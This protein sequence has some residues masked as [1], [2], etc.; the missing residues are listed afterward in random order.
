M[1]YPCACALF[2][3][4]AGVYPVADSSPRALLQR[5]RLREVE[6]HSSWQP[7]LARVQFQHLPSHGQVGHAGATAQPFPLLQAGTN[8]FCYVLSHLTSYWL[9]LMSVNFDLCKTESLES[10]CNTY[11]TCLL[12]VIQTHFW[13][14]RK[15]IKS[16]IE[17]WI[18]DME[19]QSADRRTGRTIS[20]NT[21][22]LKVHIHD[23]Y[24]YYT[25]CICSFWQT[26][27]PLAWLG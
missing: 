9:L 26:T 15:E 23:M 8:R 22:A 6:R 12:K 16:Q 17:A 25:D 2:L 18:K 11:F 5:A 3:A 19:S 27:L 24:T 4:G 14:K 13:M 21:M 20:L 7:E 1:F 10:L